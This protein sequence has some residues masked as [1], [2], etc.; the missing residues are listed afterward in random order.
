MKD[1]LFNKY[2]KI[3]MLTI[4]H[5]I[6]VKNCFLIFGIVGLSMPIDAIRV[7]CAFLTCTVIP[8]LLGI[9]F[10]DH[11][12]IWLISLPIQF[13]V[14][15]CAWCLGYMTFTTFLQGL[16]CSACILVPQAVAV[17]IKYLYRKIKSSKLTDAKE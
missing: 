14:G 2:W 7:P 1:I 15:I 5:A 12:E 11:I 17:G 6:Y 16:I 13:A 10:V 3:S 8:M 9:L 4:L